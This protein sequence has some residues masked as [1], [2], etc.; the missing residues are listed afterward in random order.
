MSSTSL[1]LVVPGVGEIVNLEDY[2]QCARAIDAIRDLESQLRLV[3]AEL[4]RA[5]AHAASVQGTKTLE[6]DDGRKAVVGG[7]VTVEYDA[8]ALLDALL[9]A[10]MPK[11]RIWEIVVESRTLKV[12]AVEAKRA[13]AAN[14]VYANVIDGCRTEIEKPVTIS[15]RR[16]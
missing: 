7:G 5:V 1:E 15:L 12:N 16:T 11:E 2:N 14:A 13:A 6:L 10:G 9:S 3:K 8:D 4:S